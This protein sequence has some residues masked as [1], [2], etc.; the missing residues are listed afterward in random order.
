[1]ERDRCAKISRTENKATRER[2]TKYQASK[3]AGA[4]AP[5]AGEEARL[6]DE[7]PGRQVG[8][9]TRLTLGFY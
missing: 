1:M 9:P 6:G 7:S 2:M 3:E 8:S 4:A 5:A